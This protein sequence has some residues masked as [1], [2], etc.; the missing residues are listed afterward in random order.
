MAMTKHCPLEAAGMLSDG[1]SN[2]SNALSKKERDQE[3]TH[4]QCWHHFRKDSCMKDRKLRSGIYKM[5]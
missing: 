1:L 3:D 5:P 2:F 4:I